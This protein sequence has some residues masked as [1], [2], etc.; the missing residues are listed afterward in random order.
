MTDGKREK[1]TLQARLR[2]AT[3]KEAWAMLSAEKRGAARIYI[4]ELIYARAAVLRK[5]RERLEMMQLVIDRST[6]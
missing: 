1:E 2:T 6:A 3:E 5:Q 4:M